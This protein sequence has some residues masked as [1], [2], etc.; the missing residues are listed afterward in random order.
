[1]FY[2]ETGKSEH[3]VL[4]HRTEEA[5]L[6]GSRLLLPSSG[7]W[8]I[9][10]TTLKKQS[11]MNTYLVHTAASLRIRNRRLL[12]WLVGTNTVVLPC[13]G[14]RVSEFF[15]PMCEVTSQETVSGGAQSHDPGMPITPF[16][17][18]EAITRARE[19]LTRK[20]GEAVDNSSTLGP[21][22]VPP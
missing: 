8:R 19:A 9:K 4:P 18:S 22:T 16:A 12:S 11:R 15:R 10:A 3:I 2:R 20:M 13:P 1:M 14:G 6:G 5:T 7:K 17:D 21:A